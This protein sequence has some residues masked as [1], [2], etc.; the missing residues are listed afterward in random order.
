[1][2]TNN[3]TSDLASLHEF[4]DYLRR[5]GL[6]NPCPAVLP[7]SNSGDSYLQ[8]SLTNHSAPFNDTPAYVFDD[9]QLPSVF[10]PPGNG[11]TTPP[12]L[13][14]PSFFGPPTPVPNANPE[15]LQRPTRQYPQSTR[16]YSQSARKSSRRSHAPSYGKMLQGPSG[17][18]VFRS[19]VCK[20]LKAQGSKQE[21]NVSIA[22]MW[23]CMP[24]RE[25]MGWNAKA[26][27]TKQE[28]RQ[29]LRT[30]GMIT[31]SDEQLDYAQCTSPSFPLPD[32]MDGV[33]STLQPSMLTDVTGDQYAQHSLSLPSSS[34]P[35]PNPMDVFAN[36][37]QQPFQSSHDVG[38]D[39][40]MQDL[41]Y[42]QGLNTESDD[43]LIDSNL[44]SS[45][46][47]YTNTGLDGYVHNSLSS[48][49]KDTNTCSDAYPQNSMA[50]L[51]HW[52]NST[53]SDNMDLDTHLFTDNTYTTP[54]AFA[55][56]PPTSSF[57]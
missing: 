20:F 52:L 16:Q 51:L 53:T 50:D 11:H 45:T 24:N 41:N 18:V 44:L 4:H 27:K 43:M 48:T 26:A 25:K 14:R 19:E 28:R 54:N 17:F 3:Q 21:K 23:R 2:Q 57:I 36:Y 1:M 37:S 40:Q 5:T 9:V 56:Y 12:N 7:Q 6:E 55:G 33:V 46:D 31:D 39:V 35:L 38:K 47:K 29:R 10:G 32:P 42:S 49:D 22:R 8:T 30:A 15:T 34:F 13:P